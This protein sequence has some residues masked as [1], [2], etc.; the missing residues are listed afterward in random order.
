MV[1]EII[2]SGDHA[3]GLFDKLRQSILLPISSS[4][5]YKNSSLLNDKG[6]RET[7]Y[8]FGI[9]NSNFDKAWHSDNNDDNPWLEVFFPEFYFQL[10]SYSLKSYK[11]NH[12]QSWDLTAYEGNRK[13]VLLSSKRNVSSEFNDECIVHYEVDDYEKYSYYNRF[14]ISMVGTRTETP[15]HHF[16]IYL[17][18]FFGN[19]IFA[20]NKQITCKNKMKISYSSLLLLT[21]I[22]YSSY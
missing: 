20:L 4:I 13:E 11:E 7:R 21:F 22:D 5:I 19:M 17:M 18:E 9:D 1:K 12:F 2:Y 8:P 3:K 6:D 10:K 14:R 16:E 15:T